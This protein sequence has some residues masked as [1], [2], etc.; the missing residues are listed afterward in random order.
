M[1]L[2]VGWRLNGSFQCEFRHSVNAVVVL[3][4]DVPFQGGQLP[5]LFKE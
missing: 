1:S 5:H 2:Q 3:F 4:L